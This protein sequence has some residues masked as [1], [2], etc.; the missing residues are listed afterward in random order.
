LDDIYYREVNLSDLRSGHYPRLGKENGGNKADVVLWGDSHAKVVYPVINALCGENSLGGMAAVHSATAP[1]LRYES[2]SEFSLRGESIAFNNEVLKFVQI[3]KV[4]LVILAGAW[5]HI[6]DESSLETVRRAFLETIRAL[7]QTGARVLVVRQI[8][9]LKWDVRHPLALCAFQG[10]DP[11]K[12]S[13]TPRTEQEE[14]NLLFQNLAEE[15]VQILDPAP[16]FMDAQ[17]QIRIV[18]G[19]KSLYFDSHHLS[20]TGALRLRPLFEPY[21]ST[22]NPVTP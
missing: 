3:H 17:K 19:G 16:Y 7:K 21:F 20:L 10:R 4:P 1:L 11:L 6:I 22:R 5:N 2:P 15:G 13:A 14:Q 18:E 9:E 8:P 12:L